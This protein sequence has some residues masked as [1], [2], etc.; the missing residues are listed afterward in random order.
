MENILSL[1]NQSVEE[2]RQKLESI[3]NLNKVGCGWLRFSCSIAYLTYWKKRLENYFRVRLRPQDKGWNGYQHHL[4]GGYKIIV[5]YTP[6]MTQEERESLGV[7]KSP[8][9]GYMT[10]DIP[11]KALDS[12]SPINVLKLWI[13]YYGCDGIQL[14]R[15]DTYYD[16]YC[17][18]ISPESVHYSCKRGGVGVPRV[19]KIRGWDEYDLQKGGNLSYTVY[20][21]SNKSDKQL[22]FYDK[23]AESG[24]NQNCYRWEAELKNSYGKAFQEGFFEVLSEA[25]AAPTV[26]ASIQVITNYYKSVIKAAIDFKEIPPGKAPADLD[27]NW[28]S[29]SNRVWWWEELLAGLEPAKLV[30]ERVPPSLTG[31]VEWI[32]SQVVSSL[33]LIKTVYQYWGI[34]FYSWLQQGLEDGERRWRDRHYQMM[35]EAILTSPSV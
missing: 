21:G 12:L 11:Q 28:A 25:I 13:D 8:N 30:L 26:E 23:N 4:Q 31:A 18:I 34:P 33:A 10:V 5:A 19:E 29:R 3:P 22:R 15:I 20:F 16:D 7:K 1:P 24:G 35:E 2:L 17:K 27:P 14:K 32:K 6:C 9:E